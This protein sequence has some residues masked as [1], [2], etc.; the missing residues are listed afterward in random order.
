[1][2]V[3]RIQHAPFFSV[4]GIPK[5]THALIWWWCGD[6]ISSL[7]VPVSTAT[8]HCQLPQCLSHASDILLPLISFISKALSDCCYHVISKNWW[9]WFCDVR[10]HIFKCLCV[11]YIPSWHICYSTCGRFSNY[12]HVAITMAFLFLK[13][14]KCMEM[15]QIIAIRMYLRWKHVWVLLHSV[16]FCGHVLSK[17]TVLLTALAFEYI[18]LLMFV[19]DCSKVL[20]A[21]L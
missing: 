20:C 10:G 3:V 13:V 5:K 6:I 19:K 16:F 1:M 11:M 15:H 18:A 7:P 8:L 21:W 14:H 2:P 4:L 12:T 9:S 17:S